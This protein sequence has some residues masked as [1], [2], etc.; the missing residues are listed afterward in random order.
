MPYVS[1]LVEAGRTHGPFF[2]FLRAGLLIRPSRAEQWKNLQGGQQ[3]VTRRSAE[4]WRPEDV[5]TGDGDIG[6][7]DDGDGDDYI[8][9]YVHVY[10]QMDNIRWYIY[11]FLHI[12][13]NGL[14][15]VYL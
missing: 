4:Q 9:I 7:N 12:I 14:Y 10:Y 5:R 13:I 3:D 11:I 1:K 2:F 15:I 8:Y 6:I